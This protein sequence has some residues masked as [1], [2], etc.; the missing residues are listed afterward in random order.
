MRGRRLRTLLAMGVLVALVALALSAC[1][2]G[3]E[4]NKKKS[5]GG[6][7]DVTNGQIAFRR[8]FDPDQ[9]KG[10]LFT[11]N[12]DGSHIRQ[13]THPR[14]TGPGTIRRRG[15]PMGEDRL[16]SPENRREH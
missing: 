4:A 5:A 16:P 11:M 13:I 6:G 14:R 3:Q 10:A 7:S 9:T 15:L 12:T 8:W 2:G 1:S